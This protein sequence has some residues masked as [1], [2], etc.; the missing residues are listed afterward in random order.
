[1]EGDQRAQPLHVNMRVRLG[2]ETQISGSGIYISGGNS[3][4]VPGIRI[5]PLHIIT[6]YITGEC[7]H[8]GWWKLGSGDFENKEVAEAVSET[9]VDTGAVGCKYTGLWLL[10]QLRGQSCTNIRFRD[11]GPDALDGLDPWGRP[12]QGVSSDYGD[13][14]MVMNQQK[15]VLTTHEGGY[16]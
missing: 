12:P 2:E 15:V 7:V 4:S 8:G 14:A 11:V 9:F 1:M 3:G 10:L 16:A 13:T 6:L 5:T